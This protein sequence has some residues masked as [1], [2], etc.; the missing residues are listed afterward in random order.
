MSILEQIIPVKELVGAQRR[1]PFHEWLFKRSRVQIR[2]SPYSLLGHEYLRDIIWDDSPDQTF[3]KAAQVGISTVELLKGIYVAEHLG[4]KALYFFQDDDAVSDFSNNRCLPI[5][6]ESTYLRDRVGAINN[7][8]LK[9]IGFGSIFFRGLYT[10]GR[11][12]SVDGDAIFFDET[13]EINP[14]NLQLARDRV[15]HSDLQWIHALSQPGLPGQDI[16]FMFAGSDQRYWHLICPSCGNKDNVLELNFPKN[17]LELSSNQRRS[18]KFPDGAT[19]YRGCENCGAQ[20]DMSKGVWVA[21]QPSKK[22]R[23][24][25]LSQLYTQICPPD[26]PNYA[27]SVM[28]EWKESRRSQSKMSRFTI[29][30]L[31]FPYGGGAARV[32]DTLLNQ[33]E[34]DYGWAYEG[35]IGAFMGVDQGDRLHVAINIRSGALSLFSF[36]EEVESWDRLDYFMEKFGIA[37]CVVDA[38]P[39][40]HSAKAFASRHPGRVAIQYFQGKELK[41]GEELHEGI[42]KIDVVS[43]DRTESL[44][45]FIDKIEAGLIWLPKRSLCEGAALSLVEDAR[46]H[47]KKLIVKWEHKANGVTKRNYISGQHV[48]NHYAMA[49][50]SATIAAYEFGQQASPMVMP[51][52]RRVGGHAA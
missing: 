26:Y 13:S 41:R 50:N 42:Y 45:A 51:I 28:Q 27:S 29:S 4:K 38:L 30:I 43:Q 5:L 18:K 21:H 10:R 11:A 32:T 31:G 17:F 2:Q 14:D 23:G 37:F 52:T 9:D 39:S 19:H 16:D 3:E 40:K 24:Y 22:R 35:A 6:N 49:M 36:F 7:V 46:R 33:R 47:L 34:G 20:L 25:H 1:M 8:G 44:D 12:K 48:E 15:M